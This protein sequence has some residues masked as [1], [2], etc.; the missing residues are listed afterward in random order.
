MQVDPSCLRIIRIEVPLLISRLLV[1]VSLSSF[2]LAVPVYAQVKRQDHGTKGVWYFSSKNVAVQEEEEEETPSLEKFSELMPMPALK[3][4]A[5]ATPASVIHGNFKSVQVNV[6]ATGKNILGDAANEP[7][8]AIDP[9]NTNRIVIGWRQFDSVTSNFRQAGN[10]YSSDGGKTWHNNTVLTKGTFRSDPV[11]GVDAKGNF[12]YNS[13]KE[14]FYTD[15]FKTV[16]GTPYTIIGPAMG[17]DKQWMAV[18]ATTSV[19]KGNL[20]E[21]WSTAGNNYSGRQFSRSTDAGKT[22]SDPINLPGSPIWGTMDIDPTG[23]LYIGALGG[24]AFQFLRSSNAKYA[25]ETPTFDISSNVDLGGGI[26]YGSSINPVGLLGQTWIATDK[27]AGPHAGYIYML[28]SVG[29]DNLNPCDVNLSRSTDGGRT[30]SK[31]VRVNDD[32]KGRGASHWFGT[33]AVAPNGRLDVVWNDNRSNPSASTSAMFVSSSYDGGATWT[34]SQQ[35]TPTF[36][37]NIGYPQQSKMGDYLGLISDKT[38][39]NAVFSAT[40]NGEEDIWF[41]RYPVS[42]NLPI[43]AAAA[44]PLVGTLAGGTVQSIHVADGSTFDVLSAK[45]TGVGQAAALQADYVL[46]MTDIVAM[47]ANVTAKSAVNATGTVQIYNWKTKAYITLQT[48]SFGKTGSVILSVSLKSISS[49]YF[50]STGKVRLQL[51]ST[52]AGTKAF[53][54]QT[55]L[56]QLQLG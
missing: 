22:W 48:F 42:A 25:V 12:Y 56:F 52:L 15:V 49:S 46:P 26:V 55:D 47:T 50:D 37:P 30:W 29:V 16:T 7:S 1:M 54:L 53:K 28:C 24:G 31:F 32:P 41:L 14:T 13:L 9:L 33:L 5:F 2:A 23:N 35:V 6:S 38:G 36:N 19:G 3:P 40:F 43:P 21:T 44:V 10:A 34:T 20:Y 51:K 8:I 4:Q 39:A 27:S 45:S 18:D 17:G 11:L